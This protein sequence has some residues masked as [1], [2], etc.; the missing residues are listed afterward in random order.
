LTR[1]A[2]AVPVGT[3]MIAAMRATVIGVMSAAILQAACTSTTGGGGVGGGDSGVVSSSGA[4]SSGSSP[5]FPSSTAASTPSAPDTSAVTS[6][7]SATMP[8]PTTTTSAA[9]PPPA[10]AGQRQA[11]LQ[12]IVGSQAITLVAL[13]G[14]YEAISYDQATHVQFWKN[15]GNS[16]S[17]QQI[18]ASSYPYNAAVGAPPGAKASGALLT[19]MSD[20]T[21][22]VSGLFSGDGSGNAVSFTTD[23]GKGWGVIKAEKNGNIAPSG[24][25]VAADRI[26]LGF[27]FGFDHGRLVTKDCALNQPTAAC[28]G[29]TTVIKYWLWTGTDFRQVAQ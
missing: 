13:A 27:G 16:T 24:Q 23:G 28:G 17:W 18:G 6:T 8:P 10:T 22:I 1:A 12:K 5:D 15:S 26:G 20:A 11:A 19:N 3:G 29:P 4:S 14:G 9:A 21:F 2:L 7:S 25:P